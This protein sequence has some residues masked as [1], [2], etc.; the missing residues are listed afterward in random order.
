MDQSL[1]VVGINHR[2]AAVAMR[3]RL[4]FAEDEIVAAIGRLCASSSAVTE[5]ALIST[6]NRVEVVGVAADPAS[7]AEETLEFLATDRSVARNLF[8]DAVYSFAGRD[9]ARH[10]FRVGAS[11]DSMVVGEPQILG[12]LKLAYAQAS[13]AH[14]VGLVLHRAFHK[15]FTVAKRVRKGTL[16][17]HGA[18]SVSSAA[19]SLAGQIFDTL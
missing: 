5:A 1:F 2:T 17:G 18:V 7:A 9:A 11:L 16:I 8:N 4:A 14:S 3:E 6:C 19:V 15:A 10:M 13:E 12:Q